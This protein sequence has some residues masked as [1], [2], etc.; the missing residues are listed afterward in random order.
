MHIWLIQTGEPLP[1]NSTAK[2]MRTALLADKLIARG[3]SVTWWASSF[4]HVKKNWVCEGDKEIEI[5]NGLKIIPLKGTGYKKN[6]SLSRFIDHRIVAGKFRKTASATPKPDLIV[7]SMPP[8]DLAYEAVLFAKTNKIPVVVDIRDEWPDLFV[9]YAPAILQ[10]LVRLFL[11]NDFEMIKKAMQ[12]ADSLISMMDS[13][14]KWGLN[15]AGRSKN[16][17]DKIF[18]L[19]SKK[20]NTDENMATLK[21]ADELKDKFVITFIGTFVDNNDPSI[22]IDCAKKLTDKNIHFVLAGDG[23]LLREIKQ[24]SANLNNVSFAGWLS[25]QEIN[26]LLKYSNV[27]IAPTKQARNAFPNKV[28]SYFSAGIPVITAF[29]GDLKEIIEKSKAGIYYPPNNVEKLIEAI[30]ALHQNHDLYKLMSENVKNI[31]EELF[32]ADKIY[33]EYANHLEKI[34]EKKHR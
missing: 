14:L 16:Q 32:D 21:F 18:Y 11:I 25:E 31:F 13:L 7:T 12:N 24:K 4:D 30:N 29:E 9:N 17:N 22:L 8:H 15:Y 26:V 2:K 33:S 28:F 19:G 3:H 34:A 10:P 20:I 27:G 6:I 5:K 1:L 23:E